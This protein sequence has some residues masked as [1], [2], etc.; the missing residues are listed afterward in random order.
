MYFQAIKTAGL[1]HVSYVLGSQGEALVVDPRRDVGVYLDVLRSQG[2]RLRYV[3]QTHRQ[4]DFVQGAAELARLTGAQVVAGKHPITG[5]AGLQVGE[6]E[7]LHLGGLT[8]VTLHTPG[9]TPESTSWAVYLDAHHALAWGVFT[10]D[11]LFAGATGRTDLEDPERTL[12]NAA[13]LYDALHQKVLPLGDQALV[14]PAHGAGSV[15]GADIADREPTTLGF[16]RHHNPVFTLS[17]GDFIQHKVRE[18]LPRPS[19]FSR[20]EEVNLRGGIPLSPESAAI[21]FLSPSGFQRALQCGV[22]LDAREPEA[23]AAGHIAGSL[24]VW[25][26]GL[27]VFGGQ[28]VARPLTPLFLVLPELADPGEAVLALARVGLD[29]V[30]GVLSG[31]FSA[32]RNAGLPVERGG[33]LT[34]EELFAHSEDFQTLDVRELSEF[35]QGHIPDARHVYVGELDERLPR[36]GLRPDLPV[37]V[38]CSVG[39][40]AGLAVSILLSHGFA[41][42]SNLLGGMTAWRR[43]ELPVR[44]GPPPASEARPPEAPETVEPAPPR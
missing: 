24:N 32:W 19:Y 26:K 15:C 22:V 10:G 18:R 29:E 17:R 6:H 35:E 7:R 27:P 21:P 44:E 23:F 36:L 2:L 14:L 42:V 30:Q 20:M 9:H 34:P 12:E 5:H 4:E 11:A 43:L 3:L 41:R 40:R 31:G 8:L 37:A 16:E 39:H 28:V 38:T 13:R 25:L 33:T 1:A